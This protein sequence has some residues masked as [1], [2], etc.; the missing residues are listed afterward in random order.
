MIVPLTKSFELF[1]FA[2][3][4]GGFSDYPYSYTA[5]LHSCYSWCCCDKEMNI[6]D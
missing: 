5:F 4:Y 6:I 2:E 1:N 3:N